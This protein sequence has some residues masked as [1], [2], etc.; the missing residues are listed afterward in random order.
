[1]LRPWHFRQQEFIFESTDDD[2]VKRILASKNAKD[3]IVERMLKNQEK[4]WKEDEKG[5]VTWEHRIYV[6]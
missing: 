3:R 2:F 6:P 5:M 4:D 1:L